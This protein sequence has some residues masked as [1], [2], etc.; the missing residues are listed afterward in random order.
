MDND[1]ENADLCQTCF[2]RGKIRDKETLLMKDCPSCKGH[3]SYDS[4]KDISQIE[5]DFAEIPAAYRG[6]L[7]DRKKIEREHPEAAQRADYIKYLDVLSDIYAGIADGRKLARSYFISAPQGNGKLS[8][9]YSCIQLA[10]TKGFTV[11]PYLDSYQYDLLFKHFRYNVEPKKGMASIDSF[12]TVDYCFIKPI[13]GVLTNR[14]LQL[15]KTLVDARARNGLGT[16]VVSRFPYHYILQAEQTMKDCITFDSGY[17]G[18]SK[19]LYIGS[20]P[21]YMSSILPNRYGNTS[22]EKEFDEF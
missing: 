10:M 6:I 5:L 20:S 22:I 17:E 21:S 19:M 8:W 9:V 18:F 7:F 4:V 1:K 11:V 14:D 2:G 16:I 15:I 13:V 12:F 3:S